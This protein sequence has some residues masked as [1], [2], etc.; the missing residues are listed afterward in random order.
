MLYNK[1]SPKF[2]LPRSTISTPAHRN[3]GASSVSGSTSSL[4]SK[5][6][7]TQSC[8]SVYFPN[9]CTSAFCPQLD[10]LS[11][12]AQSSNASGPFEKSSSKWGTK[13]PGIIDQESSTFTWDTN[14]QN[15]RKRT[16][17]LSESS[18][19]HSASST[20]WTQHSGLDTQASIS[21]VTSLVSP[22]PSSFIRVNNARVS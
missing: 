13:T 6:L 20:F 18:P 15:I 10:P 17:L 16:L 11:G 1:I 5:A 7:N 22:S 21:S 8:S 9:T 19:S 4:T 2:Y 14:L 3:S 12:S